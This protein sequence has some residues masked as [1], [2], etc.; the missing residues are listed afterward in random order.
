MASK[1][2]DNFGDFS[3]DMSVSGY[4]QSPEYAEFQSIPFQEQIVIDH[5]DAGN[6]EAG[7][8]E[9]SDISAEDKDAIY[10]KVMYAALNPENAEAQI[11]AK[12]AVTQRPSFSSSSLGGDSRTKNLGG[13]M[14][15]WNPEPTSLVEEW[16][17][18]YAHGGQEP[19]LIIA[20]FGSGY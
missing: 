2:Y 10:R 4:E 7:Q 3:T 20:Q 18:E 15:P 13:V 12:Q 17:N 9:P 16:T 6:Q 14:I 5:P 11:T 1:S 19:S 8:W